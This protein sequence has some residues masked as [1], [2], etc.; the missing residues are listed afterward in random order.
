[1]RA[2]PFIVDSKHFVQ[3]KKFIQVILLVLMVLLN[4]RTKDLVNIIRLQNNKF[5]FHGSFN[6]A[7]LV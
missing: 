5:W 2:F 7:F 6:E 4:L 3:L 1:M